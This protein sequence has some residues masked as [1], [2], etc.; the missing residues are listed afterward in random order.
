MPSWGRGAAPSA[1]TAWETRR[2][3]FASIE[4]LRS[5]L[6]AWAV[7]RLRVYRDRGLSAQAPAVSKHIPVGRQLIRGG[8]AGCWFHQWWN[9][10]NLSTEQVLV[11][12]K[13]VGD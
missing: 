7:P 5:E 12:Y 9:L 10:P 8:F 3:A 4:P 6:A 1:Q 2:P 11:S 13:W